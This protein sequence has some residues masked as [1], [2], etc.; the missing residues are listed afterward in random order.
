MKFVCCGRKRFRLHVPGE[1]MN[2]EFLNRRNKTQKNDF[3]HGTPSE[4]NE[5]NTVARQYVSFLDILCRNVLN[6]KIVSSPQKLFLFSQKII[7]ST[8][9]PDRACQLLFINLNFKTVIEQIMANIT[10]IQCQ[11]SR[12]ISGSV[13]LVWLVYP[14]KKSRGY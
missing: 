1:Y 2:S 7:K 13:E 6:L 5:T 4:D 11:N 14:V 9:Y 12:R 3:I 10:E 8:F